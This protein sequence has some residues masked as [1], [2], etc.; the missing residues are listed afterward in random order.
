MS[1]GRFT[2]GEVDRAGKLLLD[3]RERMERDGAERAVMDSDE[4][5]F[6]RA[7][8]ALTWWRD[9]H[10]GPLLEVA[11]GLHYQVERC[12]ARIGDRVEVTQRRKRLETI[13][14]KLARH[15]GSVTRMQ[16]IGGVRAVVLTLR[17]VY[18]VQRGLQ[19]SWTIVRERDY[20]ADPKK[21]GYRALHLVVM[22]LGYPMEV[23]IRTIGQDIWANVAEETSRQTGI[24]FKFGEGDAHSRGIFLRMSDLFAAFDHNEISSEELTEALR[25][26]PSLTMDMGTEGSS[27]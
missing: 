8:E 25:S 21:D 23:Q 7:W 4:D 20:I 12:D 18:A 9:Q 13:I 3:L 19:E 10:A 5:E 6:D 26:L 15:P 27:E 16:D 14:G 1:E 22:H 24:D 2:K 11:E 17:H